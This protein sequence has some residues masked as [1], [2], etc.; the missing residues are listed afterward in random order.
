MDTHTPAQLAGTLPPKPQTL[1]FR[2]SFSF[3][4]TCASRLFAHSLPQ[5]SLRLFV[6]L[7]T[8]TGWTFGFSFLVLTWTPP[9]WPRFFHSFGFA[10]HLFFS[11]IVHCY[12][13]G[14]FG[15]TLRFFATSSCSAVYGINPDLDNFFSLS[16]FL[17][18]FLDHS[19]FVFRSFVALMHRHSTLPPHH[20]HHTF[21]HST[22]LPWFSLVFMRAHGCH[23]PLFSLTQTPFYAAV[24]RGFAVSP[25]FICAL[26][27][28]L[29]GSFAFAFTLIKF[30]FVTAHASLRIGL[31]QV[32]HRTAG[33]GA[34]DTVPSRCTHRRQTL[35][36]L[37]ILLNIRTYRTVLGHHGLVSPHAHYGF[38]LVLCASRH[39]LLTRSGHP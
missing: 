33:R 14:L 8:Q 26:L 15:H 19:L 2:R 10:L 3:W 20:D 39:S 5:D 16:F 34:L 6:R 35:V 29:R 12:S 28:S 36:F 11:L 31:A 17:L 24:C 23:L 25:S 21:L 18:P 9:Y 27:S 22:G 32:R 1:P 30:R 37:P 13:F 4:F 7:N 38:T